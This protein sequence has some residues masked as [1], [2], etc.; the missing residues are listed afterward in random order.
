MKNFNRRSFLALTGMGALGAT[1][2][3]AGCGSGSSGATLRYAWWGNTVRQQNY[4]RALEEFQEAHPEITVDPEFAEYGAFQERMTTQMAARNVAD[5]FWIASSQVMTYEANGLY[6]RLD[7]IPTLD[8]SDYSDDDIASFSFDGELLT[9]PHGVFAPV[10]RFNET[11]LEEDGV[12]LPGEGWTWDELS[13]FLIDYAAD[14]PN[15]RRGASYTPDQD[16]ALEAWL[17]QRGQD[18]WTEDGSTGFDAEALGDW[19]EWWRVLLDEGAVLSLGEQ[20]GMQPDFSA[21]GD[22]ILLNFGSS[23]HIIDEA[24]MFPDYKYRLRS[25]P[26]GEGAA[27]GHR[28]LYFPRLAIYSGIDDDRVEAAGQLVN[29]NVNNSD[30]LRTVG[31]TMGAPPNPRLLQEAY[32]FASEDEVEMLGVVEAVREEERRPRYEAPPGTGTWREALSRASEG[33][34]LGNAGVSETAESLIAEIQSGIDQGA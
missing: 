1:G 29:Y 25:V 17:R 2:L 6:R 10:T 30:F 19:F 33:I 18:L 9:M 22:S 15:G 23:N 12:E 21:V 8:L 31:L 32:E 27:D 3:M 24:A 28:F 13:E 20:E 26:V 4:T 7:D 34:A 16:M 14:N 11:F 5:I